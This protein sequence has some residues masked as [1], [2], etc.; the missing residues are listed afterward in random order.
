MKYVAALLAVLIIVAAAGL[1][2]IYVGAET[3][4]G[5]ATAIA[6]GVAI[7]FALTRILRPD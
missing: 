6:M 5:K 2:M 7:Y 3:W 1:I 4:A